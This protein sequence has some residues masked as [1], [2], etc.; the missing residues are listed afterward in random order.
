MSKEILL[1]KL[2]KQFSY[3]ELVDETQETINY[4]KII[5]FLEN[6]KD[7]KIADLEAK[8]AEKDFI[9]KDLP[10]LEE[11]FK[12]LKEQKPNEFELLNLRDDVEGLLKQLA[13]K[14]KEVE[15]LKKFDDLNKTFF[16]LFRTAFKEPNK[17]D[18]LFNTLKTIQEKQDQDK[19]EFASA[20]LERAKT[21]VLKLNYE[22]YFKR[23]Y[24][25][26]DMEISRNDVLAVIDNQIEELKKEM[27]SE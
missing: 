23:F 2:E 21:S 22:E 18:D 19:I 15:Q 27:K 13:E 16:D 25:L 17:V 5:D 9:L 3:Y 20:E 10:K 6:E 12:K 26:E 7:Q 14:E 11:K 1:N 4:S 24:E 8:L